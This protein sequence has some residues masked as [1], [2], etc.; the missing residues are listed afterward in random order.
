MGLTGY[1]RKFIIGYGKIAWALTEQLKKDQFNWNAAAEESFQQLK[2]S[3]V[4]VPILALPDFTKPFIIETDVSGTG[5]GAVL[6]QDQRAVA[7]YSHA[8]PL[9]ARIK[10]VYEGELMA[11]AF[12]IQKWQPYLL[13]RRFV[14]RT[15]QLSLK[16]PLEQRLVITEHQRWL[17]KWLGY[18]FE[19][20]H[21][22]GIEN[23]AADALSKRSKTV[24]FAALTLALIIHSGQ[25]DLVDADV[26]SGW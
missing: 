10:S 15:N 26:S 7:Y 5:L 12:A 9:R 17:T 23:R 16:F 21:C 11:I 1:Y 13:G 3:M 14:V 24:E 18:N 4:S 2:K 6:I 22:S 8:L 20:Q 19:I 25:V